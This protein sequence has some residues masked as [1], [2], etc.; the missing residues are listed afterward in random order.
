[1]SLIKTT[2]SGSN[3][4]QKTVTGADQFAISSLHMFEKQL[5]SEGASGNTVFTLAK[6]YYLGSNTLMVFVNGQKAEYL[7]VP[8]TKFEYDETDEQTVTFGA[9]LLTTDVVEFVVVGSIVSV[10]ATTVEKE[11]NAWDI[12][13]TKTGVENANIWNMAPTVKFSPLEDGAVWATFNFDRNWSVA[14]DINFKIAHS[15]SANAAGTISLNAQFW[16]VNPNETPVE[17]SPTEG[18][19]EDELTPPAI[20]VFKTTELTNIKVSNANI[21]QQDC[22]IIVKLWRDIDGVAVNHPGWFEMLKFI[23][24]QE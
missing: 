23:A 13:D 2:T 4:L 5:G 12:D 20:N 6:P 11:I 9:S 8:A 24:Y 21:T 15:I 3:Y 10:D 1:M 22:V 14:T 19:A 7:A 17:A 18:P 16:V